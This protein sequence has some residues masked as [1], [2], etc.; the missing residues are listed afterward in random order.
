MALDRKDELITVFHFPSTSGTTKEQEK[1]N[2]ATT[3]YQK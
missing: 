1:H 2:V 3:D